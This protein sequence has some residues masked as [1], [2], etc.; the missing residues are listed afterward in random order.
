MKLTQ[1][2]ARLLL[3]VLLFVFFLPGA[4]PG[5]SPNNTPPDGFRALFNG[6]DLAGWKGLVG[7]P[8]ERAA[9]SEEKLAANQKKAD[10]QMRAHWTVENGELVYDG[11]GNNLCTD[12]DYADFELYLDWK[13]KEKGDSGIYLRGLPQVQI[14]DPKLSNVGSGGLYNNKQNSSKPLVVADN[15]IGEWNTF[16]I[17]MVGSQVTIRLNGQLVVDN[18]VLENLWQPNIPVFASGQIELQHHG[19]TLWF[20]NLYIRELTTSEELTKIQHALPEKARV[21][22]DQPHQ[23]LVF[24]RAAGYRHQSIPHGAHAIQLM[25]QAT[26]AYNAVITDDLTQFTPE[27]LRKFDAVLL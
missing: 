3:I 26:G 18:V 11:K 13:I 7:K 5:A 16:Y 12:T 9:M 15:P 1:K 4:V 25:G 8:H 10:Q 20:R 19:N 24:T 21:E 17:K 6:K 2:V 22:P 14:W 23:L 27:N